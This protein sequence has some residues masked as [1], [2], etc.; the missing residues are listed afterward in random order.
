MKKLQSQKTDDNFAGLSKK[1][2]AKNIEELEG[3]QKIFAGIADMDVIPALLFVVDMPREHIA[4][5]EAHKLG[6]P[7]VAICD[8]NADPDTVEYP[9]PANDDAIKA[10]KLI[11][12]KVADAAR[13]GHEAYKAKTA[14]EAKQDDKEEK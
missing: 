7:V 1:D 13:A 4:I 8:T 3:L 11:T 2:R 12:N 6:V 9:I 5:A 10:I 14:S